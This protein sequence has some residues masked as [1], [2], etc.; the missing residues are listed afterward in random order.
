[1]IY[2]AFDQATELTGYSIFK[3]MKLMDSGVIKVSGTT[4][5]RIQK[6]TKEIEY[7]ISETQKK[8]KN[9]EIRVILEDI[10]LQDNVKFGITTFKTLARLQ[11]SIMSML[12]EKFGI[13]EPVFTMSVTWKSY[14][15]VKGRNRAQQKASSRKIVSE[16]FNVDVG[17]DESD[18]I[19]LGMNTAHQELNW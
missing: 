1:M 6:I 9:E 7:K 14:A 19:L 12:I 18:A 13:D 2:I 15:K 17:E 4:P 5:N 11:G 16:K 8:F 10:Q 3:D